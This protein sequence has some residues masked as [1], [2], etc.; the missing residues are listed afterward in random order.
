[1]F[2]YG[3][4]DCELAQ[5]AAGYP[6][7]GDLPSSPRLPCGELPTAAGR[8]STNRIAGYAFGVRF[9]ESGPPASRARAAQ[10]S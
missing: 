9:G 8:R 3:A 1:M 10:G 6:A 7:F 2:A 4:R 5:A